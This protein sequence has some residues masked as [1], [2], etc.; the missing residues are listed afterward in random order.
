MIAARAAAWH[1]PG[2]SGFSWERT[3]VGALTGLL[4][5][6][7]ALHFVR[8]KVFESLIPRRLPGKPRSWVLASGGAELA[9][10]AAVAHPRTRRVG[11]GA[12]AALFVAVFPGNVKMAL[13]YQRVRRPGWQRAVAW[14]RLPLQGSLISWAWRVRKSVDR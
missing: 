9:C 12:S 5:T 6:A 1:T 10:A 2:M 7:G 4:G 13:D 14:G 3:R 11:A 8:P